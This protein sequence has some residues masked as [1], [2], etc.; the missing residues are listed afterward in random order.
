M[1]M[2]LYYIFHSGFAITTDNLTV[3]IDFYEDTEDERHGFVHD[4]LL[5]RP[6]RKYVLATHFHPDHF[7][8]QVLEWK[9]IDSDMV[10]IL[11]RDILRRKRAKSDDGVFLMKGEEYADE[12]IRVKAFGSTDSGDSFLITVQGRSFFH[13]GDLNNWHWK[14]ESTPQEIKK[15]EGDYLAELKYIAKEVNT[16]D[17]AM[18]PVDRRMGSDYSKG[19]CQFLEK[20]KTGLFVPMHFTYD[21]EGGMAFRS[22]AEKRGSAFALIHSKGQKID[23]GMLSQ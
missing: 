7:N 14:D 10:F 12:N 9:H 20:I 2:E 22:D 8:P 23:L 18:F 15:A 16:V 3:F 21:Y 1:M 4:V 13:A 6:G 5:K 11:S 19:A 17:V